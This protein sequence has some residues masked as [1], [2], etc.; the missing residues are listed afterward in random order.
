MTI[1]YIELRHSDGKIEFAEGEDAETI[2]DWLMGCQ[3]IAAVHGV[4]S[5]APQFKK[6]PEGKTP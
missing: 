3:T 4:E 6:K 1:N 5:D 2:W